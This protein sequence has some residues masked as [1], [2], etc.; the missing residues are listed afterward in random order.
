MLSFIP[1]GQFVG[2][3]IEH[4][5]FFVGGVYTIFLWPRRVERQVASA[6]ITRDEATLS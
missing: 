4:F 5:L 3:T 6:K 2:S 1:T